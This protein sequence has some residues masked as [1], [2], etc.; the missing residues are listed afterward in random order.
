MIQQAFL[1]DYE[2]LNLDTNLIVTLG[3]TSL[4]RVYNSKLNIS[5]LHG[6]LLQ[7]VSVKIWSEK[8]QSFIF[9]DKKF[10]IFPLFHPASVFYN[11]HLKDIIYEDLL[12]LG[13]YLNVY[14][15]K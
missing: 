12:K 4:H 15:K 3:N 2:M 5:K 6:Q 1:L 14:K 7:N 9:S 11:Y 13:D 10:N 8:N